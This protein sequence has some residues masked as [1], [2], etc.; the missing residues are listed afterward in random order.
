MMSFA[1]SRT[2]RLRR[3]PVVV[4][5]H[6]NVVRIDDRTAF[7]MSIRGLCVHRRSEEQERKGHSNARGICLPVVSPTS[8]WTPLVSDQFPVFDAVRL[9][10]VVAQALAPILLVL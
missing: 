5:D 7:D 9:N 4:F 2:H 8:A 3:N 6:E 10:R 1:C